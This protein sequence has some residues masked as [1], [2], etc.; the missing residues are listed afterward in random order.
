M[1]AI[2]RDQPADDHLSSAWHA[3]SD[4]GRDLMRHGWLVLSDTT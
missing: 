3:S 2:I 1:T 4:G